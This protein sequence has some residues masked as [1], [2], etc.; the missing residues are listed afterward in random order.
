MQLGSGGWESS[1]WQDTPENDTCALCVFYFLFTP[2]EARSKNALGKPI[3]RWYVGS[4]P[5][6]QSDCSIDLGHTNSPPKDR[7]E[8]GH[9]LLENALISISEVGGCD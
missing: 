3:K 9:P 5:T 2:L 4:F 8:K 1:S 6:F 7:F